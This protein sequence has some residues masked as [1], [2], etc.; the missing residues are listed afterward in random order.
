MRRLAWATDIHLNFVRGDVRPLIA[1]IRSV[2]PDA[3]LIT[4]DI[5]EAESLERA[6]EALDRALWVPAF[7]VLGNHD[8]YG[9][10]L[11]AV[12]AR[13]A[14][15]CRA[16]KWV[17]YLTTEGVVALG[18][19]TA[20]VGH[21]GWADGRL[22]DFA[23]SQVVLNDYLSIE[24]LT[25]L[26]PAERL[27]RLHKLGDEAAAYFRRHLPRALDQ[28][29]NVIVATHVPPY[30][31]ACFYEGMPSDDAHLPRVSCPTC[32]SRP[33]A[34]CTGSRPWPRSSIPRRSGASKMEACRPRPAG[35]S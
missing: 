3:V 7:I 5:A 29:T 12:R 15:R 18:A 13:V 21:D 6:L 17:R 27:A 31:E 25:G 8:F 30:R 10:S 4:G 23:S 28:Y 35:T 1:Q 22:G 11:R 26:D 19:D 9:S 24:E 32:W 2:S 33:A 20:L 34:R 14:E 16:S